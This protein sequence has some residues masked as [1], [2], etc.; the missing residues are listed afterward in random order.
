MFEKL[1]K[2]IEEHDSIVI[3]GHPNPDGDCFGSQIALRDTIRLNFPN[4]KVFAVG[5]GIR[6]FRKY[7]C[8]MDIV[9]DEFI[10]NSLAILVD[11]NDLGRMEDQRVRTAKAWIKIDHHVENGRFTEGEFVVNEHAN[12]TC[13]LVLQMIRECGW[14]INPRIADCLYLGIVTDSG[15]FQYIEDFPEAFKE[16]TWLCEQGANPKPL[17]DILNIT[18]ENALKFRGYVYSHYQKSEHGVIY[19]VLDNK[20]I[21]KFGLDAGRAGNMVNL[22]SYIEGYPVWVF[23]TETAEGYTHVEFRSNGPAVQ[24][25]ATSLGGGGHKMAAGLTVFEFNQQIVDKII[26]LCDEAVIE[27][28]KSGVK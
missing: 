3:F 10:K 9:A 11:G 6:R 12:S 1:R 19:L 22:L 17:N 24:P 15:R 8:E 25:I 14:K 5:S 27:Y 4:K 20:T 2:I 23:I 13:Q 28:R 21:T 16:V 7:I 18:Y 26:G